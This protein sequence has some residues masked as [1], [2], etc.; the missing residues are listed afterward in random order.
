VAKRIV[1]THAAWRD[2]EAVADFIAQDSPYYAASF[3]RQIRLY[4]RSL[5]R[6]S[7]RGHVVPEIGDKTIRELI[8]QNYRLIYK[9]ERTRVAILGIVH[10]ARDLKTLW[11]RRS[12]E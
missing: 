10:G 1:W 6:L 12:G 2:L 3:V 4:A 7:M 11:A 8:V 5:G 9:V